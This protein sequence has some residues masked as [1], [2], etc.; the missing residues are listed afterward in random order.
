MGSSSFHRE[1]EPERYAGVELSGY[2]VTI[3]FNTSTRDRRPGRC[4][5]SSGPRCPA[6]SRTSAVV[7]T[8]PG[9]PPR[10]TRLAG[11]AGVKGEMRTTVRFFLLCLDLDP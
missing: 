2:R 7:D 8:L 1:L 6:D 3:R 10:T 11:S 4:S 5:V 9:A